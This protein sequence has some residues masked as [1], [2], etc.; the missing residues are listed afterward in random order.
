[1]AEI[2]EKIDLNY[3]AK[4]NPPTAAAAEVARQVNKII[5]YLKSMEPKLMALPDFNNPVSEL[6]E[7]KLGPH[8]DQD[9]ELKRYR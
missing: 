2:P 3:I 1:M 9:D 5:D 7:Q 4:I 6:V 8:P